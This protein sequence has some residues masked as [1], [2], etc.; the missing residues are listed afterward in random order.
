MLRIVRSFDRNELEPEG[1]WELIPCATHG[2]LTLNNF[3]PP[4]EGS[5]CVCFLHVFVVS[6]HSQ[7]TSW[8]KLGI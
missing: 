6:S 5:P 4:R 7:H 3:Q 1:Y 8:I 2:Q